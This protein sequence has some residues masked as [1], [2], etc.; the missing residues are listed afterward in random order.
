VNWRKKTLS[1]GDGGKIVEKPKS[2]IVDAEVGRLEVDVFEIRKGSEK[3][4]TTR[5]D[6]F[7]ET[8]SLEAFKTP[9]LLELFTLF[10]IDESFRK[11]AT[12]L[13]RVLLRDNEETIQFRTLANTVEREG[14]L[15]QEQI[16][17]KAETILKTHGFSVQGKILD[18]NKGWNPA[19]MQGSH[20]EESA[21]SESGDQNFE[22]DPQ[23]ALGETS[24]NNKGQTSVIVPGSIE[25][26]LIRKAIE[27][28]NVGKE[29][30]L[31]IDLSELHETFEDPEQIKANISLDDVLSKKQK[32]SNREKGAPSKDK[33]EFVKNTVA[34]LQNG[35]NASYILNAPGIETIMILVLAFLVHNGSL[36]ETGQLIFFIDGAADLRSAI[37]SLFLDLLPFKIILDWFHLEKK[38]KERLSAAMKGKKIRNKVL[39]HI[40]PLLWHGK[41]D[42]A[43][44]YLEGLN[45]EDIKNQEEI[46]LLIGYFERNRSYIPCY[47]L[48]Q[49][50][51]LRVSSNRGEKAN[52]LV[53]SS[54][55]KHN[56]MSWSTS[57]STSLATVTSLHLNDEQSYWLVNHDI[58]FQFKKHSE[59]LAA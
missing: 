58:S 37:Q 6:V 17:K 30:D 31:Q 52:D 34:H 57:G 56:G 39:D 48:R 8:G 54:R 55:Q 27:E 13:N 19:N 24:D 44:S 20:A 29:K 16:S 40:T 5:K 11:S 32:E 33:K 46:R 45:K 47:A 50:L 2:Y 3:V 7:P 12:K 49:K 42:A 59:D 23:S 1:E 9:R 36:N 4:F 51:G 10:P 26:E 14:E 18:G 21:T 41:I 22:K 28:L 43:I 25:E 15:I 35:E 53:V 38:C